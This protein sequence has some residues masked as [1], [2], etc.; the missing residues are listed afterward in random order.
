MGLESA[1][2]GRDFGVAVLHVC[3][4]TTGGAAQ[5]VLDLARWQA[6]QG[7]SVAVASPAGALADS[8]R[9]A[10]IQYLGWSATRN[11]GPGTLLEARRLWSIYRTLRPREVWLHSSKAGLAG[12]LVPIHDPIFVPHGWSFYAAEGY[13]SMK[14]AAA[15]EGFASRR[16]LAVICVSESEA[17]EGRRRG[18]GR[19]VV[20]PNGVDTDK[21]S[22][23]DR[24]AARARLRL[25]PDARIAVCVGR[26]TRQ[27][28]QDALAASWGRVRSSFPSAE[29]HLVGDGPLKESLRV[30]DYEGVVLDGAQLDP[31]DWYAAADLVVLASRWEGAPLVALEALA[32]G[33]P[34]IGYEVGGLRGLIG[35]DRTAETGNIDGLVELIRLQL[36][37]RERSPEYWRGMVEHYSHTRTLRDMASV[38]GIV[39]PNCNEQGSLSEAA[40]A[41][42]TG[43]I[44]SPLVS[45][46]HDPVRRLNGL[47]WLKL[48]WESNLQGRSSASRKIATALTL[49]WNAVLFFRVSTSMLRVSP[50][51][52]LLVKQLNQAITGADISPYAEV[53][54]GLILFHP[55]GVVIGSGVR[56][57]SGCQMQQG[58]TLGGKG[59]ITG[60]ES[61]TMTPTVGENVRI[62]AGARIIGRVTIGL[63]AVV[64][65][66]SVVTRDMPAGAIV[67]GIPGR[68]IAGEDHRSSSAEQATPVAD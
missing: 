49:R 26:L 14:M 12:R 29:L 67:V 55:N 10:G 20:R 22:P 38:G 45:G 24:L 68:N 6:R 17:A 53:G 36:N 31:R 48:D 47:R 2:A 34:L 37:S 46:T 40:A 33:R 13:Y 65:A 9:E 57:G 4:P 52:S 51:L 44:N 35:P 16:T 61:S 60:S 66:N 3:Q 19:I 15:W 64:G 21:Y 41:G 8:V 30:R 11:P 32:M 43:R 54:P 25:A 59:G 1:A 27:K 18:I 62:G 23:R 7:K 28:G 56:I 63:D 42:R 50:F 5:V 39:G 58:V